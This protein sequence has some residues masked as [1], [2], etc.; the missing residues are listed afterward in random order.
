MAR[1][2][3]AQGQQIGKEVT[4]GTAVA[5]TKR[6]GALGFSLNPSVESEARRPRGSKY[7]SMVAVNKEWSEGDLTG[8]ATYDE[9]VYAL[10]SIFT[11]ATVAQIM[12]A[13]TPTGA[14]SWT[15][16]PSSLGADN[17]VTYTVQEGQSTGGAI[18]EQVSHVLVT[19][20]DL[21]MSRDAVEVGGSVIGQQVQ[22]G[23]T[24][25]ANPTD[26][27]ANLVPIQPGDVCVYVSATAAGLDAAGA[28]NP[29]NRQG[30]V[31]SIH[32]SVGGR[33]SPVWYLNCVLSSFGAFVEAPEPDFTVDYTVEADAAGM[34]WL[35]NF[36][37]G[38][39]QF[40]RIEALGPV[41]YAGN[42]STTQQ[43]YTFRWDFAVKCLEPGEKSDEDGVYAISP[44]L[45]V[46]HDPTWGKATQVTVINKTAAL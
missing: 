8:T 41:I 7:A 26:V 16:T 1:S 38:T 45:Q 27:A 15:F 32:P 19:D 12:D 34:A 11:T 33:F 14:Y 24:L 21:N 31:L 44:V 35:A 3:V 18:A 6:L 13:A 10:S 37:A 39:T 25:T 29:A 40:V 20:L 46:V 9:I 43:R 2:T 22:T 36:R 4:P 28:S 5:A 23:V 30:K 17:P 42:G